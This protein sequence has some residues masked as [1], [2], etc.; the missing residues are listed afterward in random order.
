MKHVAP[1]QSG[2]T[3]AVWAPR[4]HASRRPDIVTPLSHSAPMEA[5]RP[6]IAP[7]T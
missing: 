1:W 7:L 2:R 5:F 4:R 3:E 6:E